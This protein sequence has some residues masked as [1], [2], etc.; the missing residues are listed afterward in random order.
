[1]IPVVPEIFLTLAAWNS[2]INRSPTV[3]P[4]NVAGV[5]IEVVTL[6]AICPSP[7]VAATPFPAIVETIEV[8][9]SI[10]RIRLFPTSAT[11]MSPF[12][13]FHIPPGEV[14]FAAVAR[15]L[16]ANPDCPSCPAS[17]EI[18]LVAILILRI[19]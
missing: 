3:F 4:H 12:T 1:M 9:R 16:S 11:N 18:I 13:F 8:D 17:V 14:N 10:L 2:Q 7:A 6:F 19:A 15:Q 5:F